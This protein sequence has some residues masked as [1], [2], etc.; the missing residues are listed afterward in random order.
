[1]N[2][3]HLINGGSLQIFYEAYV[4]LSLARRGTLPWSNARSEAEVLRLK[5]TCD[6]VELAR[7]CQ[8]VEVS[9]Q[10]AS[11][12]TVA[13]LRFGQYQRNIDYIEF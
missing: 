5:Q 3:I 13:F 12:K 4:I 7:S 9:N 10:Y 8:C 6:I 2:V 1:M 11:K